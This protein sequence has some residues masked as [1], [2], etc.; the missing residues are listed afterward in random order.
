[1]LRA[2]DTLEAILPPSVLK[3]IA[4]FLPPAALGRLHPGPPAR[5]RLAFLE[6]IPRLNDRYF[7]SRPTSDMAERSHSLH[8]VRLLPDLGGQLLR[9]LCELALMTAGIAWLDLP[10]AP[11]AGLAAVIAV[12]LPFAVRPLLVERDLRVRTHA[13]ALSR[14]YLDALLGLVAVRVH[15][16]EPAVRREHESLLVEWAG[17]GLARQ[18]TVVTV[19]GVHALLGFGLAAWLLFGSLMRGSE[20]GGVLLLAYWALHMPVLGQEVALLLR[21]YPV[22]RNITLRLLEPLGA[23]EDT[24]APDDHQAAQP[25]TS[26]AA[27]G[28]RLL[29]ESVS[30]RAAGHTILTDINLAIEARSHVAIVGPSGAGKSSLVGLLLGWHRAATGQICVD[31][32]PLDTPHLEQLRRETAWVDPAVQLWNRSLLDN[33]RYGAHGD[34]ALPLATVIE[35]AELRRILDTLPDGFQTPLGEGGGLVS[36]GEGQRVRFGRALLRPGIRLVILDEPFA[37]STARNGTRS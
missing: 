7:Q 25:Q 18:R 27:P 5:L 21:Q 24:G 2:G 29:F 35:Q 14:F 10:S 13:G 12:G 28:V 34:T 37:A 31:G 8:Q 33:L 30:V 11:V 9:L 22:H 16:A 36:G 4:Y 32:V 23:L 15:G 6:K 17:A 20:A 26:A 1:V 3:V 19:E